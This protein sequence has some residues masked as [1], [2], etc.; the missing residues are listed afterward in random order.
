[1]ENLLTSVII[2]FF[3]VA[4]AALIF[5][6]VGKKKR[7]KKVA[8]L[9]LAQQNGWRYEEIIREQQ[10][11]YIL[12]GEGWTLE[13]LTSSSA[14]TSEAGSSP[15]THKNKWYTDVVT[16][17]DGMVMIGKKLPEVPFGGISE[18]VMQKALRL[19]LGSQG[20]AAMGLQEVQ[21]GRSAFRERY[22]VWATSAEAAE[23]TL[24]YELE[25]ALIKW[26]GKA[27][28]LLKLS[29]DGVE[30]STREFRLENVEDVEAL[31]NLGK[32]VLAYTEK[33]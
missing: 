7:E 20:E 4:V 24:T 14:S 33:N 3:T 17:Q 8:I 10:E 23:K 15:L 19:M 13:A 2:I 26:Q 27:L 28:P 29:G 21:A 31:V 22:S 5:I 32:V 18:M 12:H 16:L 30:I 1:M 25:N 11:G 9:Q 6:I